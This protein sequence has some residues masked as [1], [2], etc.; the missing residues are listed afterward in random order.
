[1]KKFTVKSKVLVQSERLKKTWRGARS[2]G[3]D[4]ELSELWENTI[5]TCFDRARSFS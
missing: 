4:S 1:M 3:E 5:K 2:K